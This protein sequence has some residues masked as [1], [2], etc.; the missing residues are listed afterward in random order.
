MIGTDTILHGTGPSSTT[1]GSGGQLRQ[2][3]RADDAARRSNPK[4]ITFLTSQ[5]IGTGVHNLSGQSVGKITDLLIGDGGALK[6]VVL[7]VGGVLGVGSRRIA[8]EPSALVL[9]PGG[10]RFSAMLVM[11]KD[12]IAAAATFKPDQTV[13]SD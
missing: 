7:D 13:K 11:G 3:A 5:M 4:P 9:Y 12:T 10:D 1:D 6:A 8:V 2:V